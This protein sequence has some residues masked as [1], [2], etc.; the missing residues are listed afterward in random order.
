MVKHLG[1]AIKLPR[2]LRCGTVF[3]AA[4]A[5]HFALS[6]AAYATAV[7]VYQAGDVARE[8]VVTP[9]PLVVIDAE[10]TA[11]LRQKEALRFPVVC[12]FDASQAETAD[13][14]LRASFVESRARFLEALEG[15]FKKASLDA[16]TLNSPRFNRFS[17]AF[18]KENKGFPVS[19]SLA[20]VWAQGQSGQVLLDSLAAALREAMSHPVRPT[21]LPADFKLGNAIRLISLGQQDEP[22]AIEDLDRPA[23]TT[24]RTNLLTLVQARDR[25]IQAF[26]SEDRL[27]ARYLGSWLRPNCFPD[28]NL[29]QAIRVRHTAALCA[30][31]HYAAGQ[32][33]VNAGQVVD[34][35]I[36]AAL[37][38]LREKTAITDLQQEKQREE[39]RVRQTVARNKWIAGAAAGLV[40]LAFGGGMVVRRRQRLLPV[41]ATN[42]VL[43]AGASPAI[44][45]DTFFPA[46]IRMLKDK[47][48][49]R[50]LWQRENLLDTQEKAAADMAELEAR[51][52]KIQAP[53]QE[54]LRV[55]EQR[56]LELEKELAQ[57]G[58]E[59]RALI[60]LKI[61]L[62]RS[63]LEAARTK[64][65]LN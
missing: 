21:G 46:W 55:Y 45:S 41:P 12:R 36:K 25:L 5:C 7:P 61:Q 23:P 50:L 13:S 15:E 26:P 63:Q 2:A 20:S 17:A 18:Q 3:C 19:A 57:K 1:P 64:V 22:P 35:K 44:A 34:P 31:D 60:Q 30:A 48:V 11:A 54:R 38:Q 32:V 27:L 6:P 47:V 43:L 51:L 10:Q 29:T 16:A 33:L 62:V 28:T 52:E 42:Q 53:L 49:Q 8:Q 58:E 59:N 14:E 37:D 56:I 4:A 39:M 40:C 9:E 24:P 65:G